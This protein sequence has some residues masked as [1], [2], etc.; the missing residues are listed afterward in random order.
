MTTAWARPARR[1]MLWLPALLAG[2][3]GLVSDGGAAIPAPPQT[4]AAAPAPTPA[5]G[6]PDPRALT[7]APLSI[8]FPKP[9]R[10]FLPNG[11]LIYL[12]E[13]HELPLIDA[14]IDFKTGAIFDPPDKAGL[15]SLA[16][17]LMRTGGTE[18]SAPD[19]I[20]ESLEF[21]AARITLDAGNDMLSGSV[22]AVKE[23][24]PEALRIFAGMLRSP[25]FDPARI[26]VEKARDIEE[27]RRRWDDPGEIAGLNF[28]R[29]V[30][31]SSNPWARLSTTGSVG[32]IR[33]DD[34]VEF[35]R[36]YV[37]PNNAVMGIAGDFDGRR[38]K[39]LL[40]ET[41][42]GWSN[43]KIT[44]PAVPKVKDDAPAGLHLIARPLTQSR[45][46]IGH[47]G[48]SRFD[49]D[50]FSIKILNFILGEGGFT[51]R[52]MKE[53]RSNRGL[54]YSVGGGIGLDSD[55]G[56]FEIACSTK[57]GSTV[58]AIDLIRSILK[59]VRD[60]G[61]TDQEVRE[62]KEASINSFVFSVDGT[63]RFMQ[64]FLYYD[65]YAYPPDFLATYRDNLAKVTRDQVAQVARRRI[66]PDR[67]VVLVVGD[68]KAFDRPLQSLG[69][70][71]P[72]PFRMDSD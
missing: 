50:K 64:A 48:V 4:P 51:S 46:E 39:S 8:S 18:A 57:A 37:R 54:A 9:E 1:A 12:F 60:Q 10:L 13:D 71:E 56:L 49:P 41:F 47:L 24:F 32:R 63:V 31:G 58:E 53:V 72:R 27:I 16:A 5:T 14:A 33:R 20:D 59:Q 40:E 42:K 25:R 62:A 44:P 22:S 7:Y 67:L 61:P 3:G 23:R 45:V 70:G 43:A 19:E 21:M 66:N 55:R 2:L 26:E 29:L 36:R 6:T 28:R 52:L 15:A 69:L 65:F 68:D 35:H 38:M 17:T 30:Y 34:L 11:L